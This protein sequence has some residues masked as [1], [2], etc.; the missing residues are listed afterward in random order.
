MSNNNSQS[1]SGDKSGALDKSKKVIDA[2]G[3]AQGVNARGLTIDPTITVGQSDDGEE[4]QPITPTT[5]RR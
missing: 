5:I 1:S 3:A 2:S 4:E